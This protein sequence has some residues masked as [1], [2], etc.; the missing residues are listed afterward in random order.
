MAKKSKPE[1]NLQAAIVDALEKLGR[2]VIRIQCGKVQVRR[3]WM[4]LAPAGTP[5]LYVVGFG[6][7]LSGTVA[8]K[9]VWLETKTPTGELNPDQKKM[10][11]TLREGGEYVDVVRSVREAVEACR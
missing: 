3:G 1:T 7:G 6:F 8:R 9:G 11:R 5:D 2:T 10:H 4:N